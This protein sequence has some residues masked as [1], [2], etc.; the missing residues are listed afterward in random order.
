MKSYAIDLGG[1][2]IKLAVIIDGKIYA[3]GTLESEAELGLERKLPEIYRGLMDLDRKTPKISAKGVG[4][5]FPGIIHPEKKK[6]TTLN[7]KFAD[8]SEID[9]VKWCQGFFH[10]PV[11]IENDANT[12]LLGELHYGIAKGEPDTVLM[13]LGTG[14]GTAAAMGGEL[15]RGK[16]FQ[17]GCFGGHFIVNL[18][19]K[20]ICG[21]QGCVEANA[22]T[23]ALPLLIREEK[24]YPDSRLRGEAVQDFRTLRKYFTL[25]D[26]LAIKIAEHCITFWGAGI[27]NMIHAYDPECVVLSGGVT[28]FRELTLPIKQWVWEH[29]WTPWGQVKI[30]CSQNPQKSVLLGLH[31]L[32]EML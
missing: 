10:L 3:E 29:A 7:D 6:I 8:A 4:I 1:T 5:A 2:K 25:E 12:A 17:A 9:L 26:P 20:C 14:V 22:S 28:Q 27:V 19:R 11:Q 30:R 13:I 23:W 32:V 15:V 18:A 24:A 16:H 31:Y 21:N